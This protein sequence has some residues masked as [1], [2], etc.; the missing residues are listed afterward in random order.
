MDQNSVR[1]YLGAAGPPG[2]TFPIVV[3]I[4]SHDRGGAAIDQ[5]TWTDNWL[6][7]LAEWFRGATAFPPGRGVW[8]D[9]ETGELLFEDT[10]VVFTIAAPSDVTAESIRA[11]GEKAREFG[12]DTNQGEVGLWVDGVYHAF[13]GFDTEHKD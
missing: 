3:F 13:T 7:L 6:G 10:A 5:V 8:R 11:L 1:R 9:D 12:K 4:P 2:G